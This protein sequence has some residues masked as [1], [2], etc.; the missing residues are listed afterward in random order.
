MDGGDEYMGSHDV[1]LQ[2]TDPV[3]EFDLDRMQVAVLL[4][5][6]YPAAFDGLGKRLHQPTDNPPHGTSHSQRRDDGKSQC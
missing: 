6:F 5:C 4:K 2:R 1:I 3:D